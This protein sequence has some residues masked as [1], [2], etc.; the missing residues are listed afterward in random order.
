M[1]TGRTGIALRR[2]LMCVALVL[3]VGGPARATTPDLDWFTFLQTA[4]PLAQILDGDGNV[5]TAGVAIDSWLGNDNQAPVHA[6]AEQGSI[7]ILKMSPAGEYLWHTFIG[8]STTVSGSNFID[9]ASNAA[10]DIFLSGN[11]SQFSTW[12]GPDGEQA[13]EAFHGGNIDGFLARL[14]SEGEYQWHR[15]IGPDG[16]T[17]VEATHAV[18]T[19]TLGNVYTANSNLLGGYFVEKYSGDGEFLWRVP[20]GTAGQNGQGDMLV[21][22][23]GNILVAHHSAREDQFDFTAGQAPIRTLAEGNEEGFFVLKLDDEGD[24]LWHTFQGG[25]VNTGSAA[26]SNT[27]RL[28]MVVSAAGDIHVAGSS[29]GSWQVDG[30]SALQPFSGSTDLFVTTLDSNGDYRWHA[31]WGSDQNDVGT[32]IALDDENNI[33]LAAIAESNWLGPD[34]EQPL[35]PLLNNYGGVM[36]GI[37]AQGTYLWHRF[38]NGPI[39]AMASTASALYLAGDG[40]YQSDERFLEDNLLGT[41][42]RLPLSGSAN[43]EGLFIARYAFTGLVADDV[44]DPFSFTALAAVAPG[45]LAQSEIVTISGTNVASEISIVGGEYSIDGGD[46]TAASGSISSGQ[47]VQLRLQASTEFSTVSQAVLSIGGVSAA[48]QVTTRSE[49]EDANGDGTDGGVVIVVPDIDVPSSGGGGGGG[50]IGPGLPA[51]LLMLFG[52]RRCRFRA[53]RGRIA[54]RPEWHS[55]P[56]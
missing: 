44:P 52:V 56:R 46:F 48:F 25:Q 50:S 23:A 13:L 41:D 34:E 47:R 21:D 4:V 54:S 15:F 45:A 43:Q 11:V 33:V 51:L 6:Y 26:L 30:N 31:F 1:F 8:D 42:I 12:D 18:A 22:T 7:W 2:G 36:L 28:G 24:Y 53:Y 14:S 9:L 3:S 29:H 32:N 17:A 35:A 55:A 10:G 40:R 38:L 27:V 39:S 49:E 5:I 19:D 20:Y 37:D 16:A